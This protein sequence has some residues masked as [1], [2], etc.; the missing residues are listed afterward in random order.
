MRMCLVIQL[1]F[2][3]SLVGYQ[4]RK[5]MNQSL[6][7]VKIL[8]TTNVVGAGIANTMHFLTYSTSN[9]HIK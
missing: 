2:T 9:S 6:F 7:I 5:Y 1:V 4:E 8:K 3:I